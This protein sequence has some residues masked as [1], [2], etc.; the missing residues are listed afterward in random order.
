VACYALYEW[1]GGGRDG[2]G[3]SGGKEEIVKRGGTSCGVVTAGPSSV[4]SFPKEFRGEGQRK[5]AISL[6]SRLP[7]LRGDGGWTGR[8]VRGGIHGGWLT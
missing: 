6:A 4:G 8:S 1:R 5:S 7:R 2:L 3:V